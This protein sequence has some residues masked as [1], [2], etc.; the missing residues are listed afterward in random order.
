MRSPQYRWALDMVMRLQD[1]VYE[2]Y[3]SS[4]EFVEWLEHLKSVGGKWYYRDVTST[5]TLDAVNTNPDSH[6]RLLISCC[7]ICAHAAAP[8]RRSLVCGEAG[9]ESHAYTRVHVTCVHMN[10]NRPRCAL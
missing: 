6:I 10:G 8:R 7:V 3:G 1:K 4:F 2:S 9:C 5:A